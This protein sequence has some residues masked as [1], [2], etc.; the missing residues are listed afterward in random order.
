M[1]PAVLETSRL[2]LRTPKPGDA[3]GLAEFARRNREH[4][5]P[6]EPTRPPEY[7]TEEHWERQVAGMQEELRRG[8]LL[9]L[10][11]FRRESP[12]EPIRGRCT[13]SGIA[14]GPF[15]AAYL[16]YSLD[17][18]EEGRGLMTEALAEAI[19]YCFGP[20]NLHRIQANYM[21]GN[22]RS[23]R[24]LRKLGFAPEGYARDYLF[25]DGEWRDHILTSLTNDGWRPPPG[26]MGP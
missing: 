17:R 4:L 22:D 23:G 1:E 24:L 2:V 18:E 7:F 26:G 21:P 10:L 13:F 6:W 8:S 19:R 25:L 15:Q 11:I 14:R 12:E 3:S 16:G 5:A 9:P 20:L